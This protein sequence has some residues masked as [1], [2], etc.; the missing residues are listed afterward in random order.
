MFEVLTYLGVS[1]AVLLALTAL[2][3]FEDVR[4]ERIFLPRARNSFDAALQ[5]L[6]HRLGLSGI[7]F[8][9]GFLR[10][11]MHYS[12]H[13]VLATVLHFLRG[14]EQ[15]IEHA[16]RRNRKA[17]KDIKVQKQNRTHLDEIAEHKTEVALSKKQKDELRAR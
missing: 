9:D 10:L 2:Y 8:R 4:G 16:V 14:L 15:R 11:I 17:A 12:V 13:T 6:G 7:F 3:F 1:V 5:A